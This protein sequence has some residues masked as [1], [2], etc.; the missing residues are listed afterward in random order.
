MNFLPNTNTFSV[1][2][3]G[4]MQLAHL[5]ELLY[6]AH[7]RYSTIHVA[8]TYTYDAVFM[9]RLLRT[10]NQRLPER[11]EA[12]SQKET[13]V[14]WQIWWQKPV[15]FREEYGDAKHS[16]SHGVTIVDGER[17]LILYPREKRAVLDIVPTGYGSY[18]TG[19][20]KLLPQDLV[21]ELA[22]RH[23]VLYPATLLASHD[24]R[25]HGLTHYL[26]RSVIQVEATYRSGATICATDEFFWQFADSY[27]LLVDSQ[28]GT[29]LSYAAK[30]GDRTIAMLN[31]TQIS[32]DKT[33][34]DHVF[35]TTLP[36]GFHRVRGRGLLPG[37]F[38]FRTL[39]R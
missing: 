31:V 23:V 36:P 33:F 14:W 24:L 13:E 1:R 6:T 35:S 7:E 22:F 8:W 27:R 39:C 4:D 28:Y 26:N 5:L 18:T 16:Q 2:S 17:T 10:S 20:G 15:R 34:L 29:L 3:E 19:K 30:K 38:V 21:Q 12:Q 32:Y 25:I 11:G 37:L 9:N